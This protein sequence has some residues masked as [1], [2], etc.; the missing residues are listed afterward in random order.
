MWEAQL[1]DIRATALSRVHPGPGKRLAKCQED[2]AS[3]P[4]CSSG[5]DPFLRRGCTLLPTLWGLKA[6][7]KQ[8][9]GAAWEGGKWGSRCSFVRV[10]RGVVNDPL[11]TRGRL[12]W[13]RSLE[14]PSL[15][16]MI[17]GAPPKVGLSPTRRRG[18][19]QGAGP[20]GEPEME[21]QEERQVVGSAPASALPRPGD[22]GPALCRA[23]AGLGGA[24]G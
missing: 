12:G 5:L 1:P 13:L 10:A 24:L 2:P 6:K 19:G 22:P 16:K 4:L 15:R 3:S 14:L 21:T 18:R 8:Q 7:G 17:S 11:P 20:L 9:D 23:A